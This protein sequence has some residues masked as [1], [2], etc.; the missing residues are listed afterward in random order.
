M[1]QSKCTI[2]GLSGGIATGK[3]TVTNMLINRGYKVIDA[4]IISKEVVKAGKPAYYEILT[5]FGDEILEDNNSINRK[6]LGKLIFSNSKLR[7]KLNEIVH[8]RIFEA[9]TAQINNLCI[10]NFVIFLDIPLLFENIDKMQRYGIEFDETWIVYA[11][12]DIQLVRLMKRDNIDAE[13]AIL[14]ISSQMN[15]GDKKKMATRILYNNGDLNELEKNL[16]L[17]LRE[18]SI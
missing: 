1:I 7:E 15:L 13:E 2:I 11:D 6:K 16:E 8:P 5:Y 18:L 12:E 14:K 9:I 17:I 10:D 4:D 3:S